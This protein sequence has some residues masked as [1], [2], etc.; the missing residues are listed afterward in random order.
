MD[1]NPWNP[2]L[3]RHKIAG[4]IGMSIPINGIVFHWLDG[5]TDHGWL[6]D[7]YVRN[8]NIYS[9]DLLLVFLCVAHER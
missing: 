6:G 3:I 8:L 9:C 7:P 4:V 5:W 2:S 1:Y